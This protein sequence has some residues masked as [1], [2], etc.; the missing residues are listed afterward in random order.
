[1]RVFLLSYHGAQWISICYFEIFFDSPPDCHARIVYKGFNFF[2]FHLL[3]VELC[4][5][6]HI[7]FLAL[8]LL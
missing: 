4:A 5:E 3:Y 2:K 6:Y 7:I 1:M 8:S